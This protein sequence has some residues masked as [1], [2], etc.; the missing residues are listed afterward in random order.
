MQVR[1]TIAYQMGV[2]YYD[3]WALPLSLPVASDDLQQVRS[4]VSEQLH[5]D[6][7][8]R[9]APVLSLCDN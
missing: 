3:L 7:E 8:A 5:C 6:R 9:V 4:E 2:S 1:E